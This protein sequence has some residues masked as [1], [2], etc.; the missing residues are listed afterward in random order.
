MTNYKR[1]GNRIGQHPAADHELSGR[2]IEEQYGTLIADALH[3]FRA[4]ARYIIDIAQK[5]NRLAKSRTR[6]R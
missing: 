5:A 2:E 6:R 4:D 3:D 1:R